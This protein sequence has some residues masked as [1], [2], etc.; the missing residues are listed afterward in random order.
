[1]WPPRIMAKL[2]EESK[3]DEPGS[4]VAVC[5]PALIRSGSTSSS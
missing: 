3:Y 4:T 5:L 2:V 1:M